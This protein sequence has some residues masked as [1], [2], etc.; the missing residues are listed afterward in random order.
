MSLAKTYR[1]KPEHRSPISALN[2]DVRGL[3]RPTILIGVEEEPVR[4]ESVDDWHAYLVDRVGAARRVTI[5]A[6][7]GLSR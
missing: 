3:E 4:S 2:V 1:R 7:L 6:Y 5:D